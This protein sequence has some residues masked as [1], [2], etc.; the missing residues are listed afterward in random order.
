M[1]KMKNVDFPEK[2]NIWQVSR[3]MSPL[4]EAGGIKDVVAGLSKALA[5][6]GHSVTVVLPLYRF[7]LKYG[8]GNPLV[9]IELNVGGL[10]ETASV[11][12][13]SIGSVR[14]LLVAADCF[15]VKDRVY[16]YSAEEE[17]KNKFHHYGRGHLDSDRMNLTLQYA[18]LE[19][20]MALGEKPDLFHLHD[21]HCGFLPAIMKEKEKYSSFF[22]STSSLLTI[23]NGGL[24]YQQNIPNP[25]KASILTG[26]S[27]KTLEKVRTEHGYNPII[28]AGLYGNLNTVSPGYASDIST[29]ADRNCGELGI[30]LSHQGIS[31]E[32]IINGI[33]LSSHD[34]CSHSPVLESGSH[35][36]FLEKKKECR[37]IL[38]DKI[39]ELK[40][41]G[42]VYGD[43][44][45][46]PEVP[47]VTL[48]SRIAYQKGLDLFLEFLKEGINDIEADFLVLGEG[49]KTLEEELAIMADT[50]KN[51]SYVRLYSPSLS[52]KVF[53]GGDFFLIPSRW[54]P[55]GLTDFIAQLNGN[56]PI[57]HETGGLVKTID[58]VNG[59]SYKPNDI[60]I[61]RQKIKNAVALYKEES[62]ILQNI[63]RNAVNIINEKYT[64]RKVLDEGYLPLYRK[65][66]EPSQK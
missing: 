61:L 54:E 41:S 2:L 30:I 40:S 23:H 36:E 1:K 26:L 34:S 65:I 9:N 32:G 27:E 3:E 15:I 17:K 21:G 56:I 49:D 50:C 51:F 10:K 24:V 4:A 18:A 59:F 5:E 11:Y 52:D 33:D 48:Q 28:C 16:T 38:L 14:V 7:L 43:I 39:S 6:E 12:A 25:D 19:A 42:V 62:P 13:V 47:L 57:V 64:W 44:G 31:L 37:K 20:S 46:D 55:C 8:K 53:A 60:H 66:T 58:G 45:G 63:R 22:A 35:V 29:G